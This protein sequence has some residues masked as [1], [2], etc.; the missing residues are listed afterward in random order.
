M[1]RVVE[2]T[3]ARAGLVAAWVVMVVPMHASAQAR[4][5]A[6]ESI[7]GLRLHNV[8]ARVESHQGKRS[9]RLAVDTIVA[10]QAMSTPGPDPA[11]VAL[12]DGLEFSN[13]VIEVEVA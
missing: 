12:V 9:V 11:L 3:A 2:W 1:T 10:R 5:L 4:H 7:G 6:L 13:G 8:V